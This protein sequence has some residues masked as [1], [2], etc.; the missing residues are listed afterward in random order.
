M[1][2]Q[3]HIS[4][5]ITHFLNSLITHRFCIKKQRTKSEF[6]RYQSY[7]DLNWFE[8]RH[9][10]TRKVFTIAHSNT[11]HHQFIRIFTL[12]LFLCRLFLISLY[13][14]THSHIYQWNVCVT[15]S[16]FILEKNM[17]LFQ[18]RQ[19]ATNSLRNKNNS[20]VTFAPNQTNRTGVSAI[21]R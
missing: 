18:L 7:Y 17:H 16:S 14:P 9:F 21:E 19:F 10:K 3:L 8:K 1:L 4:W 15:P 5:Q 11:F 12:R 2:V 13:V 20:S 6:P